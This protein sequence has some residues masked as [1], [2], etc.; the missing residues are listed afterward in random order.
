MGAPMSGSAMLDD[1]MVRW[2]RGRCAVRAVNRHVAHAHWRGGS[3]CRT[4]AGNRQIECATY[5]LT[6]LRSCSPFR[7]RSVELGII[8]CRLALVEL[9]SSA[10]Y[11]IFACLGRNS[12]TEDRLTGTATSR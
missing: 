2:T 8:V 5:F 12:H 3:S 7:L 11:S 1:M 6:I 4:T 9:V 10:L